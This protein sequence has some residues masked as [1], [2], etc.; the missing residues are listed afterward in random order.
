M[1]ELEIDPAP[2]Q[3]HPETG[4]GEAE[5]HRAGIRF[6]PEL[7]QAGGDVESEFDRFRVSGLRFGDGQSSGL[8][9]GQPGQ[10]EILLGGASGNGLPPPGEL[11]IRRLLK[12]GA[13]GES[14]QVGCLVPGDDPAVLQPDAGQEEVLGSGSDPQPAFTAPRGAAGRAGRV[15]ERFRPQRDQAVAIPPCG[16][17]SERVDIRSEIQ[18]PNQGVDPCGRIGPPD[19]AGPVRPVLPPEDV[20]PALLRSPFQPPGFNSIHQLIERFQSGGEAL[21]VQGK[22]GLGGR[23]RKGPGYQ[24]LTRVQLGD[25]AVPGYS[26]GFFALDDCPGGNV[27][28]AVSGQRAVMEIDPPQ[29]GQ[30][31]DGRRDRLEV[32]NAQNQVDRADPGVPGQVLGLPQEWDPPFVCPP[33][34][35]VRRAHDGLD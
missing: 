28:P 35:Q 33:P 27:E 34:G 16:R 26:V 8:G 3:H 5:R 25:H 7:G 12:P 2:A 1:R 20:R 23:N 32:P 15:G 30:G 19:T 9:L 18:P 24:N 17:Q 22:G 14:Q 4:N 6:G 13:V 31:E 11:P 10:P 29:P 21:G